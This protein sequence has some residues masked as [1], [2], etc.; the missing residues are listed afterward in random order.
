MHVGIAKPQFYVF[1][2]TPMDTEY[3]GVWNT[4]LSKWQH[5]LTFIMYTPCIRGIWDLKLSET[6]TVIMPTTIQPVIIKILP[7][8]PVL[9]N[10]RGR[11]RELLECHRVPSKKSCAVFI[12]ATV[13]LRGYLGI[14]WRQSNQRKIVPFYASWGGRVFSQLSRIRLELIRR[15]GCLWPC[16]HAKSTIMGVIIYQCRHWS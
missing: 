4:K 11:C 5:W 9:D 13:L 14:C 15:T 10:L 8:S 2:M 12:R 6:I 1:G 3:K 16:G 7:S